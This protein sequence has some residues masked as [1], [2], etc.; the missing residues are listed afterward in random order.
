VAGSGAAPAIT[1][2]DPNRFPVP[3]IANIPPGGSATVDVQLDFTAVSSSASFDVSVPFSA[4]GGR[5]RGA[6]S[7]NLSGAGRLTPVIRWDKPSDITYGMALGAGQLNATATFEGAAVAGTFNYTPAAGAYLNAGDNQTL[8]VVFAPSDPSQ[9]ESPGASVSINVAP[10]PL[11]ISAN[12]ATKILGAANPS[13]TAQYNGFA[14]GQD[15]SALSGTLSCATTA[16]TASPVGGYPISCSGQT[17][18]NYAITY[19]DALSP[20][21]MPRRAGYATET[22]GTSFCRPSAPAAPASSSRAVRYPRSFGFATPTA[23]PS[24]LLVLSP[25]TR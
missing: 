16:T 18:N 9:F 21:S 8:S 20:F 15:A 10:A 5:A 4:N 19:V 11:T 22:P 17:S 3:V 13:F 7:T 23:F 6:L 24:G 2:R 14:L 1:S 25:V 12:N